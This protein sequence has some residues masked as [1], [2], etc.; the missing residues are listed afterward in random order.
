M[1]VFSE[2]S[3]KSLQKELFN[4]VEILTPIEDISRTSIVSFKPKYKDYKELTSL[5]NKSGFRVRQVAES[6]LNAIRVSTHF[7]NTKEEIDHL[8]FF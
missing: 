3:F 7:F 5:I 8:V 4:D 6:D 1:Y 2:L